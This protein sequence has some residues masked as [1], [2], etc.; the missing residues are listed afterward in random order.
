MGYLSN[1]LWVLAFIVAYIFLSYV[2]R[3][4][5]CRGR[6]DREG[7]MIFNLS[8]FAELFLICLFLAV[9]GFDIYFLIQDPPV[10]YEW[11]VP[12]IFSLYFLAKGFFVFQARNCYI[13]VKGN[14]VRYQTPDSDG[15]FIAESYDLYY[16]ESEVPA[17]YGKSHGWNLSM[18]TT[19]HGKGK[20]HYFDL[21]EMNLNGFKSSLEKVLMESG[22][23]KK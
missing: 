22:I 8:I 16:G 14:L 15:E 12:I 7:W 2:W 10:W 23:P 3:L 1:L 18:K 11:I 19:E 13:H 21:K 9:P 17:L 6:K 20:S 4:I 5:F